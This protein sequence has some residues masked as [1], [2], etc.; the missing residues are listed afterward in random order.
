ML[1]VQTSA[2]ETIVG[3]AGEEQGLESID[4]RGCARMWLGEGCSA[5]SPQA[6]LLSLMRVG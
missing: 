1:D 5:L 2:E 4:P 6:G 3:M